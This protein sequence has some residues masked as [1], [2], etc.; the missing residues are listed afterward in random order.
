MTYIYVLERYDSAVGATTDLNTAYALIAKDPAIVV[1]IFADA[2]PMVI[3]GL[4]EMSQRG[5]RYIIA[6]D[7]VHMPEE[8]LD[9]LVELGIL[10]EDGKYTWEPNREAAVRKARELIYLERGG[11]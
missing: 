6:D 5:L 7:R 11:Q 1:N 4:C 3:V 10:G 8:L 9:Q 2:S